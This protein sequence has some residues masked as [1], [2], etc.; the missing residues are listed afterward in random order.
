[1]VYLIYYVTK[2]LSIIDIHFMIS[3]SSASEVMTLWHYRNM[4]ITV[5]LLL[6][7]FYKKKLN[8]QIQFKNRFQIGLCKLLLYHLQLDT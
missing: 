1:M 4:T 2:M 6:L 7:F 3:V 8:K 5:L